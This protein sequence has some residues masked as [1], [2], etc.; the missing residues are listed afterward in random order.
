MA[1]SSRVLEEQWVVGSEQ[2][3]SSEVPL[4]LAT[5]DT[6]ESPCESHWNLLLFNGPWL[7]RPPGEL[8]LSQQ[9]WGL[10][11]P[12]SLKIQCSVI[13]QGLRLP[14]LYYW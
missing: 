1:L 7:V 2:C 14:T 6:Q 8:A 11:N 13:C 3:V 9:T 4:C 10:P 5:E 12:C